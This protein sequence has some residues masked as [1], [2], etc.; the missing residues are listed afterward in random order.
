MRVNMCVQASDNMRASRYVKVYTSLL[1][2]TLGPSEILQTLIKHTVLHI[3]LLQ[4][5]LQ[6]LTDT[7]RT[8]G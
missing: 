4:T 2:I 5:L 8:G 3:C 7:Q 1:T 6:I